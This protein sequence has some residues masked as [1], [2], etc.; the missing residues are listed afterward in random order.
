MPSVTR[1]STIA[2]GAQMSYAERVR[3]RNDNAAISRVGA[4]P[5][6]AVLV[7][8]V[9]SASQPETS[10]AARHED[11]NDENVQ[12]QQQATNVPP[13]EQI[14]SPFFENG[15]SGQ[16]ITMV[17]EKKPIKGRVPAVEYVWTPFNKA[18]L[19][20]KVV[21]EQEVDN[22]GFVFGHRSMKMQN[23]RTDTEDMITTSVTTLRILDVVPVKHKGMSLF[24]FYDKAHNVCLVPSMVQAI[25][26]KCEGEEA[27]V[28][29]Y[30]MVRNGPISTKRMAA[31]VTNALRKTALFPHFAPFFLA[32]R[33]TD[34]NASC[35][36]DTET[37]LFELDETAGELTAV[38]VKM[39]LA[40]TVSQL[41][42]H[43][44]ESS[45]LP[46]INGKTF[47]D[48][49][50]NA[51]LM[52]EGVERYW[53]RVMACLND[54]RLF[55]SYEDQKISERKKNR[56]TVVMNESGSNRWRDKKNAPRGQSTVFSENASESVAGDGSLL[57]STTKTR[58]D[59]GVGVDEDI[60]YVD[61]YFSQLAVA[62]DFESAPPGL[63][64]AK[65]SASSGNAS[66]TRSGPTTRSRRGGR[67][68]GSKKQ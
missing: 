50:F 17:D 42:E 64:P 66:P 55:T 8:T 12:Q 43:F 40:P 7:E 35:I 24:T 4:E 20:N 25:Q 29:W 54:G 58:H 45:D 47:L 62:S 33:H 10:K 16:S 18:M 36:V 56:D 23:V 39:L 57:Q 27:V 65:T 60:S 67:G 44:A 26:E 22:E 41:E 30:Q 68:G 63:P 13:K 61:V 51:E 49:Y 28:G 38:P 53:D 15:Q 34:D 52:V 31:K 48:D 5:I 11:A 21:H 37:Q 59:W 6:S 32:I 9:K 3:V 1:S 46:V 2:K 14:R 19:I